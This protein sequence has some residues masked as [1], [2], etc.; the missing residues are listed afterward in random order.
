[1]R[2]L[3]L[4][5]QIE[6]S[7]HA[8]LSLHAALCTLAWC[9]KSQVLSLTNRRQQP[10][11]SAERNPPVL[12]QKHTTCILALLNMVSLPRSRHVKHKHAVVQAPPSTL[13][14]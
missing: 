4:R 6:D 2:L 1:M 5:S 12:L 3:Q 11:I 7:R 14:Y 8:G 10:Q 13:G 9:G